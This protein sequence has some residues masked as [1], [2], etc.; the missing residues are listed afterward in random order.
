MIL[1]LLKRASGASDVQMLTVA[2]PHRTY[3]DF[4]SRNRYEGQGGG[5]SGRGEW[6]CYRSVSDGDMAIE[7]VPAL[8]S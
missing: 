2:A 7:E 4:T 8:Y 6:K 3:E 1:A 5:W